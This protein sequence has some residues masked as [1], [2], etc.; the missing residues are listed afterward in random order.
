MKK[1]LFGILNIKALNT[2]PH[3]LGHLLENDRKCVNFHTRKGVSAMARIN[4]FNQIYKFPQFLFIFLLWRLLQRIVANFECQFNYHQAGELTEPQVEFLSSSPR[5]DSGDKE[6]DR[7]PRLARR[8]FPSSDSSS[9]FEDDGWKATREDSHCS[10]P[11]TNT[12]SWEYKSTQEAPIAR[13][14]SLDELESQVRGEG[15]Q[16]RGREYPPPPLLPQE[17]N[18]LNNNTACI[19]CISCVAVGKLHTVTNIDSLTSGLVIHC[20]QTQR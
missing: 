2:N 12:E 11:G 15:G 13:L 18:H 5:R 1:C 19:D 7:N 16:T 4:I 10:E 17:R 6:R 14:E 8:L 9:Q 20:H 3:F